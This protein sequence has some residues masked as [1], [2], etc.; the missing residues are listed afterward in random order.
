MDLH[1]GDPIWRACP[2]EAGP[3]TVTT[4]EC[5]T[6]CDVAI[7]GAG[8]TGALLC[9][10]LVALGVDTVLIDS[11]DFG[12]GSTAAST[13][14]L[15]PETD[16]LLADLE[17]DFGAPGARRILEMGIHAVDELVA[18]GLELGADARAVRRPCLYV[19]SSPGDAA[20]LEREL[21]VRRRIGHP[22]ERLASGDL[23][24]RG[25]SLTAPL[26]IRTQTGA[27]VNAYALCRALVRRGV[28]R[29]VR[30]LCPVRVNACVPGPDGRVILRTHAGPSVAA[31]SVVLATGYE[32]HEQ[33]HA[34]LGSLNSTWVIA[35]D[36]LDAFPGWPERTLIWESARPYL[37]LRTAG[38][39]LIAGG[40]DE[41]REEAHQSERRILAKAEA[42]GA[43][44]LGMF[45]DIKLTRVTA[46]AGVFGESRDGLAYIGRVGGERAQAPVY[47]ALGYGGNG[48]TFAAMAARLLADAVR[49][50]ANRDA[51]LFVFDRPASRASSARS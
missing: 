16:A 8:I 11:R 45:P 46:W 3:I 43:K 49:G 33:V 36:P 1:T 25:F 37:Y 34:D 13:G 50:V 7:V 51:E 14:M 47:A 41:P 27:E 2:G 29:G 39:R 32:A 44:V 28:A 15:M 20:A 40:M 5:D 10:R 31:R 24:E 26:A 38:D 18:L 42:L 17:R 12:A 4:L 30:A 6:R 48:I 19:A 9:D 35:S 22:A 21:A 23:R